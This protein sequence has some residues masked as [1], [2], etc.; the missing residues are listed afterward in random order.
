MAL[1]AQLSVFLRVL[2]E[3]LSSCREVRSLEPHTFRQSRIGTPTTLLRGALQVFSQIDTGGDDRRADT[4]FDIVPFWHH[5]A[6]ESPPT[7]QRKVYLNCS[8]QR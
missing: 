3:L 4:V 8:G 5:V 1:L 2:R 6:I 7:S